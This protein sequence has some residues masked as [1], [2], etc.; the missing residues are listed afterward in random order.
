MCGS[1]DYQVGPQG[2]CRR[3]GRADHPPLHSCKRSKSE[4][5]TSCVS[6]ST[7]RTWFSSVCVAVLYSVCSC[8]CKV[9][10]V[11]LYLVCYHVC[12]VVACVREKGGRK[13]STIGAW[14][15][16]SAWKTTGARGPS[17]PL[18]ACHANTPLLRGLGYRV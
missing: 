2:Y 5:S 11:V 3:P 10:V 12:A 4:S 9:C 17:E 7:C 1:W 18:G 15:A 14:S 16:S 6:M 8:L 13:G